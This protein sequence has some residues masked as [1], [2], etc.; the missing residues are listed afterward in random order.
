MLTNNKITSNCKGIEHI[1]TRPVKVK[2]MNFSSCLGSEKC[3][4]LF[5]VHQILTDSYQ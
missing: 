3:D 1:R 2:E 5:S 4:W